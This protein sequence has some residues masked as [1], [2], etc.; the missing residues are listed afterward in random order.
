MLIYNRDVECRDSTAG[1]THTRG[2]KSYEGAVGL[3]R[4][5]ETVSELLDHIEDSTEASL[6]IKGLCV[7]LWWDR[8]LNLKVSVGIG[9]RAK[10]EYAFLSI[11][12]EFVGMAE[13]L[14]G[15]WPNC[16]AKCVSWYILVESVV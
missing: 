8:R 7:Q 11:A 15:S 12:R 14:C 2:S 9:S 13:R 4:W 10:I 6:L 16:I 3:C 1:E 5:W